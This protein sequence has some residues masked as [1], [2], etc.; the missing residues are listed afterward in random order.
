MPFSRLTLAPDLVRALASLGYEKPFPVQER[1]IPALLAGG[2]W[3][4]QAQTG[5]GKTVAFLA[6]L[7]QLPFPML[8]G[9]GFTGI[10]AVTAATIEKTGKNGQIIPYPVFLMTARKP[11]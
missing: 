10:D 1:A 6:P 11:Q 7:L 8:A 3:V 9:I 2:D 5:S 4:V